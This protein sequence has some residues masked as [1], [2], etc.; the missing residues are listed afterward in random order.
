MFV[1]LNKDYLGQQAGA[2]LD[3]AE[4]T[5]ANP[6]YSLISNKKAPAHV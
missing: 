6:D 2:T 5:V 1:T 3:I 4:E